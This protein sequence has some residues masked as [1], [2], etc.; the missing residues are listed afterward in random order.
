MAF[1]FLSLLPIDVYCSNYMVAILSATLSIL[2][3]DQERVAGYRLCVALIPSEQL[4][5]YLLM[6]ED[7]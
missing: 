3:F 6:I 1:C 5:S 4:H 7:G 2:L